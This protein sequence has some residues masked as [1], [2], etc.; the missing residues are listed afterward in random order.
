MYLYRRSQ[1][2]K[3]NLYIIKCLSKLTDEMMGCPH[4]NLNILEEYDGLNASR[5]WG[6]GLLF[7]I[8]LPLLISSQS[9]DLQCSN[10]DL[11]LIS[12]L[13]SLHLKL[14]SIVQVTDIPAFGAKFDC[15]KRILFVILPFP[16]EVEKVIL[17]YD[18]MIYYFYIGERRN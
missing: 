12:P 4:E 10:E 17:I 1:E 7:S 3:W 13:Y 6:E 15:Q 11:L 18:G 8:E 2:P 16:E 9:L 5:K 14:P